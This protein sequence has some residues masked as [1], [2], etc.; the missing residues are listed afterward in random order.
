[1]PTATT[2]LQVFAFGNG[3]FME[4]RLIEQACGCST[5]QCKLRAR[6]L[7]LALGWWRV[8]AVRDHACAGVCNGP[9]WSAD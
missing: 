4:R 1:M 5:V 3:A 7:S 9:P 2:D 6:L 8:L